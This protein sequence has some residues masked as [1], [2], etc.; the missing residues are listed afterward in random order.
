MKKSDE[1]KAVENEATKYLVAV[2][3]TGRHVE[4]V[5]DGHKA[6]EGHRTV[7][8]FEANIIEGTVKGNDELDTHGDSLLVA[9]AK[10]ILKDLG[11]EDFAGYVFEDKASN[12]PTGDSFVLSHEDRAKA[13]RDGENPA[14]KQ[15][16]ISEN[17]DK[18]EAK[19][20]KA[21]TKHKN[22]AKPR[23]KG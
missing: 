4:I 23:S 3:T 8:E 17:I 12:A 6:T 10:T 1:V 18:A 7:G 13:V 2:D 20:D 22:D 9:Q 15:A 21:D 11:L 14:D 5:L 16:E 19:M